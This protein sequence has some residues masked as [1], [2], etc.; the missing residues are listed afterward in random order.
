MG[1]E[2]AKIERGERGGNLIGWSH[3]FFFKKVVDYLLPRRTKIRMDGVK[4]LFV[5]LE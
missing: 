3:R 2:E 4:W 1:N 5:W